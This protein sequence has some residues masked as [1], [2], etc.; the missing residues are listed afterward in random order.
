MAFALVAL[1]VLTSQA[2]AVARGAP[3]AAGTIELC[4]GTGPVMI[5]VDE[6]GAPV[7][8]PHFCPDQALSLVS[9]VALSDATPRPLRR[10][11]WRLAFA[12]ASQ[13][14]SDQPP[15][16]VARAPPVAA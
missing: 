1:L 11:A 6:S 7:T 15:S 12:G 9:A 10:T 5:A 4:T 2:M 13:E 14:G 16:T 8:P 3:G